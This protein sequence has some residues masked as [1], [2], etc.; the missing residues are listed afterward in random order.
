MRRR[1]V[2]AADVLIIGCLLAAN[3]AFGWKAGRAER[4]A[5]LEITSPAARSRVSLTPARRIEVPGP[6]GITV[7][8]VGPDGATVRSSPCP[9]QIC[10][11]AGRITRPGEVVACVP[12]RVVLRLVGE[13]D[14]G[15]VDAVSR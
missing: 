15:A 1:A 9:N 10:V 2:T 12:N 11:G 5:L 4:P 8:D 7:V 13:G 3:A 14:R 6:L